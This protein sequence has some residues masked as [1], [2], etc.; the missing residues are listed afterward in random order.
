MACSIHIKNKL[1]SAG[2]NPNPTEQLS[3]IGMGRPAG[4]LVVYLGMVIERIGSVAERTMAAVLKTVEPNGSVGS[5]AFASAKK[6]DSIGHLAGSLK[7]GVNKS[8][9]GAV[10]PTR[11]PVE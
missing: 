11:H 3:E 8:L 6:E 4:R 5:S 7:I 9:P 10:M 2:R 1:R